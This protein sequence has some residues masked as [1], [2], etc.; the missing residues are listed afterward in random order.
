[1]RKSIKRS[2]NADRFSNV[3]ADTAFLVERIREE[4]GELDL[5]LRDNYFNLYYKG[6][7]MAKVEV[8]PGDSGYMVSIHRKFTERVDT[9]AEYKALTGYT[10]KKVKRTELWRALSK[11]ALKRIASSIKRVNW[12]EEVTFEQMLI[13]DN[14]PRPEFMIIDRQVTGGALGL[15]R[16]DLLALKRVRAGRNEYKF[17][18][19]EVKLGNNL[20]LEGDVLTTQLRPYIKTLTDHLA[21]FAQCYEETYRQMRAMGLLDTAMPSEITIVGPVE[22][23]IVV[24]GYSGIAKAAIK[25]LRQLKKGVSDP[26]DKEIDKRISVWHRPS[27]LQEGSRR[28]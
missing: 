10:K 7:S 18:I 2:I 25:K 16:L 4:R 6:N 24:G 26:K 23:M 14:P 21:D 22:G 28:L 13:T 20:E 3:V 8:M 17:T 15:K 19:L 5:R 9:F 27:L 1:M 11:T 12:G